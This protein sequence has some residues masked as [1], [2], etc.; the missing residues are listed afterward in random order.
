MVGIN[1]PLPVPAANHSFG[2]WKDSRFGDLAA[3]GP[4]GVRLY[5]IK[6]LL[7]RDGCPLT[8][9]LKSFLL[10]AEN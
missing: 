4:N 9:K 3:Y 5:T 1:V 7:P 2:G 10:Q 6:K 8:N